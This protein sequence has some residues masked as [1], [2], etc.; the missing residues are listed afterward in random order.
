MKPQPERISPPVELESPPEPEPEPVIPPETYVAALEAVATVHREHRVSCA[1][2]A[3]A[4]RAARDEHAATLEMAD[5]DVQRRIE[6][7]ASLRQR[8]RAAMRELM[9]VSMR[10]SDRES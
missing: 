9:T 10:C 6:R 1:G 8:Q 5:E 2:F 4:V 7:D 3:A